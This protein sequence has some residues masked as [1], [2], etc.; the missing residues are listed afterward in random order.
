VED[1]HSICAEQ[2]CTP[3]LNRLIEMEYYTWD[4]QVLVWI[5]LYSVFALYFSVFVCLL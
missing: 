1:V 2:R 5:K 4:Y 3:E